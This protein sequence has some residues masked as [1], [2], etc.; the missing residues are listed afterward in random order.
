MGD[1]V[2]GELLDSYDGRVIDLRD[3]IRYY[4][5]VALVMASLVTNQCDRLG[6]GEICEF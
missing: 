6:L 2:C 4:R 5:P 3:E 1:G